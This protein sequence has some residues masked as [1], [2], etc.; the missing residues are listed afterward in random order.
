MQEKNTSFI[1]FFF[2]CNTMLSLL[3][4]TKE[5]F[6]VTIFNQEDG[7]YTLLPQVS[8]IVAII[9]VLVVLTAFLKTKTDETEKKKQNI[10]HQAACLFSLQSHSFATSYIKIVPMPWGGS[11][12]LCSMLFVTLIGYWYGPKIGLIAGFAYVYC[13]LC[14]MVVAIFFPHYRHV[15]II[16]WHFLRGLSV[17]L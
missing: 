6:Y 2:P 11:I 9:A 12:T 1:S 8:H 16:F 3:A 4:Y 10:F 15:W 5:D 14:R 17:F 13:N 7:Y